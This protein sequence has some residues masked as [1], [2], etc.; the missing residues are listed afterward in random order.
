ML[1]AIGQSPRLRRETYVAL[2]D[3]AN[4]VFVSAACVWEASIKIAGGKLK[5][6]MPL[7]ETLEASR[8][9]AL[10]I[11]HD[12]AMAAGALPLHHKDPFDRMLIAQAQLEALTL[13]TTDRELAAYDVAL[14]P[15]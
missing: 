1:W 5:L 15:A 10:D 8:F 4:D 3:P 9:A 11:T 2:S 6:P 12:H 13:V 7:R 14:L